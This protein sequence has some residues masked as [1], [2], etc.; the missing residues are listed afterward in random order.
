MEKKVQL[1]LIALM[2]IVS[3]FFISCLIKARRNKYVRGSTTL[4]WHRYA[5]HK[6]IV[7]KVFGILKFLLVF[8]STHLISWNNGEET[9]RNIVDDIK[10]IFN[11]KNSSRESKTV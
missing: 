10:T 1:Q 5:G 2:G 7:L 4:L 9:L 11:V 6:N 8:V 3:V